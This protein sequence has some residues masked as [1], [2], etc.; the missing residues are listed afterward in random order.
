MFFEKYNNPNITFT[1]T[2]VMGRLLAENERKNL[3]LPKTAG[4]PLD[5]QRLDSQENENQESN[6]GN[7][8]EAVGKTLNF[9]LSKTSVGIFFK[10]RDLFI[11]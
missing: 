3:A 10:F 2:K 11:K 8:K 4:L 7:F 5:E 9:S 1:F 6:N